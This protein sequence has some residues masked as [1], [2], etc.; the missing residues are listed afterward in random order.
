MK[1]LWNE[2]EIKIISYFES[3]DKL[4]SLKKLAEKSNIPKNEIFL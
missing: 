2:E 1:I 3:A 4:I